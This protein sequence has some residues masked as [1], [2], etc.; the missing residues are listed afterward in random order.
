MPHPSQRKVHFEKE[1]GKPLCTT[2]SITRGTSDTLKVTC[3][4]CRNIFKAREAATREYSRMP[5]KP[6]EEGK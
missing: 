2:N 5:G 6:L 4:K 3:S 1:A